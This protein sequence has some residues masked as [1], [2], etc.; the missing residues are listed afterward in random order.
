MNWL[1]SKRI[2]QKSIWR[3]DEN[4]S[5]LS[6]SMSMVTA[7]SVKSYQNPKDILA[8]ADIAMYQAK[9][10]RKSCYQVFDYLI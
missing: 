2:V 8:D 3:I 4:D 9:S 5:S 10:L 7:F 1:F 6:T